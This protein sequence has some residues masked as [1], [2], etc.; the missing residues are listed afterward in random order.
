M[1]QSDDPRVGFVAYVP[2]GS[3][4]RGRVLAET[5]RRMGEAGDPVT[6][7]CGTC[8]GPGL[9]GLGDAPP[10]AGRSPSYLARQLHGFR[11]GARNGTMAG[12]MKPVVANITAHDMMELTA[13]LASLPH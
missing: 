10:L 7:P 8:H 3:I 6:I 11:S 9:R 4:E 5:G 2:P 12:L 13:Y 1:Q